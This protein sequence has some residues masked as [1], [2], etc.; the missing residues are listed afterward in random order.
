[1]LK[2]YEPLLNLSDPERHNTMAVIVSLKDPVNGELLRSAV[3]E[4]RERFP[5][6]YVRA[7]CRDGD[8]IPI[9]NDLPMIVR[10]T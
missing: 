9:P 7:A 10:N 3:E 2:Y 1:M 8:L 6:F 4:L 5:Y